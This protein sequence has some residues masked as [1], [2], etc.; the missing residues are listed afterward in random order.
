MLSIAFQV[1]D[2]VRM[3]DDG[4]AGV[5]AIFKAATG[6]ERVV[7]LIKLLNRAQELTRPLKSV[8]SY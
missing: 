2:K 4:F 3:L 5:E 1:G 6:D 7:L 8:A